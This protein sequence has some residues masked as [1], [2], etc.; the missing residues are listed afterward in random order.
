MQ[1]SDS[2][3]PSRQNLS[4]IRL[5]GRK[6]FAQKISKKTKVGTNKIKGGQ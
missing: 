6:H 1:W 2:L 3:V 4:G 5:E